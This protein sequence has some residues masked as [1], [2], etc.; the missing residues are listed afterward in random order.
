MKFRVLL[1]EWLVKEPV[2][3]HKLSVS[4]GINRATLTRYLRETPR[5]VD[6][7][8]LEA[9]CKHFDCRPGDMLEIVS[10]KRPEKVV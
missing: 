4:T 10:E 6:S 9:L 5:R 8:K 3:I 1:S 2:S 7:E